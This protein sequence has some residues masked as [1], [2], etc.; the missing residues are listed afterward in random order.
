MYDNY[1]KYTYIKKIFN[2]CTHNITKIINNIVYQLKN[3]VYL[4]AMIINYC[5][6]PPVSVAPSFGLQRQTLGGPI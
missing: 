3:N 1:N 5:R 4:L 2:E 6:N